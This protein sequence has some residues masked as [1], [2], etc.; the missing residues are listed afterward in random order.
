MTFLF[1]VA[2]VSFDDNFNIEI[3]EV[4]EES[5][6]LNRRTEDQLV[7]DISQLT[8]FKLDLEREEKEARDKL[9]LPYIK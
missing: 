4:K 8:T 3:N 5:S 7:K 2:Y 9:V 6:S 1:Q